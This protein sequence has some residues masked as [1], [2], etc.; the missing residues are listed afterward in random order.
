MKIQGF[1]PTDFHYN[2]VIEACLKANKPERA[3]EAIHMMLEEY[4]PEIPY[5]TSMVLIRGFAKINK[6]DRVM[7]EYEKIKEKGMKVK[8]TF[9]LNSL[10]ETILKNDKVK[11]ASSIFDD[12][13]NEVSPLNDENYGLPKD[14]VEVRFNLENKKSDNV[15]KL[16]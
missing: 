5:S 1:I 2:H 13:I 7:A 16:T 12:H 9:T 3:E 11:L 6:F 14:E 8:N 4:G 15:S 10:L